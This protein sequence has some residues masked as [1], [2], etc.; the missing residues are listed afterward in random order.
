MKTNIQIELSDEERNRLAI[1]LDGPL[2][3]RGKPNTRLISR[4]EVVAIAQQHIA[5]LVNVISDETEKKRMQVMTHNAKP[6]SGAD[7]YRIDHNDPLTK[8]MAR[9]ED[10]GYV[11]GWNTAARKRR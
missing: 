1:L 8:A 11:R 9:P 3:K 2:N 7:I 6:G 5:G 10:P 4:K